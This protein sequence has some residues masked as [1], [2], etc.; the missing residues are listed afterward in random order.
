M[1]DRTDAHRAAKTILLSALFTLLAAPRTHI[2]SYLSILFDHSVFA[3]R[4]VVSFP[5]RSLK[6]LLRC[7]V[8][9]LPAE[10]TAL[11]A[12]P[13]VTPVTLEDSD[14]SRAPATALPSMK[15]KAA[16]HK[17]LLASQ[18]VI[19]LLQLFVMS[20]YLSHVLIK[21]F[22]QRRSLMLRYLVLL[23]KTRFFIS[24]NSDKSLQL[25]NT[26][27]CLCVYLQAA[28]WALPRHLGTVYFVCC[29]L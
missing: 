18:E 5:S 9:A 1:A 22:G 21:L 26:V 25:F 16:L 3:L 13:I 17:V 29:H 7:D 4:F 15:L 11:K 14:S 28:I 19:K 27:M 23:T 24:Q 6:G 20:L 2:R 8:R 12:D 10:F